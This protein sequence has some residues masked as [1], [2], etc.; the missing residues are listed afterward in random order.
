[1]SSSYWGEFC[2]PRRPQRR[3][4]PYWTSYDS[5]N[6]AYMDL[7]DTPTPRNQLHKAQLDAIDEISPVRTELCWR[8]W[9]GQLAEKTR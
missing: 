2:D 5:A 4:L 9:I 8:N 3:G 1:M 7:A 6:E